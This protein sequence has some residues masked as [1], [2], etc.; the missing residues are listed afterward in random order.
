M[1]ANEFVQFLERTFVQQQV[2]AFAC[3]QLA[4]PVFPL[5]ALSATTG[6][7]FRA[8]AAQFFQEFLLGAH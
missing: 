2:D 5:A 4:C 7:G 3:R 8:P 6:F 1:V